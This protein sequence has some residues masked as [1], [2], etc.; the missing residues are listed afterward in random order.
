MG[1]NIINKLYNLH[2]KLLTGFKTR[3]QLTPKSA[4]HRYLLMPNI[5]MVATT[6]DINK[7][8]RSKTTRCSTISLLR[9][10][11]SQT[12]I[13]STVLFCRVWTV[14][15]SSW[16]MKQRPAE[17]ASFVPCT[18]TRQSSHRIVIWCPHNSVGEFG[19]HSFLIPA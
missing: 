1:N 15:S 6:R 13:R 14:C 2:C 3:R 11:Y 7:P 8:T 9:L 10:S 16:D 17:S 19:R 18:T 12:T 4:I 5:T